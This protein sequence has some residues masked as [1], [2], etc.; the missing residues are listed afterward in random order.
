[1]RRSRTAIYKKN[2]RCDSNIVSIQHR[3]IKTRLNAALFEMAGHS[4]T[5]GVQPQTFYKI[6]K[7]KTKDEHK[8]LI[9]SDIINN[10]I[11]V[12]HATAKQTDRATN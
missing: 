2:K 9:V 4:A 6:V 12:S 5:D 10:R 1:M 7:S 11:R 8:Q 3:N